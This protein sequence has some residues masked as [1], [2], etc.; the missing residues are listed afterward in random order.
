[1]NKYIVEAR[2]HPDNDLHSW[3]GSC[4][5]SASSLPGLWGLPRRPPSAHGGTISWCPCAEVDSRWP[6]SRTFSTLLSTSFCKHFKTLNT[7]VYTTYDFKRYL[8]DF[9]GVRRFLQGVRLSSFFWKDRPVNGT[10]RPVEW[11]PDHQSGMN[12]TIAQS[13]SPNLA[14]AGQQVCCP[15]MNFSVTK[16]QEENK[17]AQLVF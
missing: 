4:W 1:M 16:M 17:K 6:S 10:V 5:L 13:F 3:R 12:P 8:T 9:W 7:F 11:T 2:G 15:A 14:W